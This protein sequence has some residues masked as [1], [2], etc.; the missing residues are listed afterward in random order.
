MVKHKLTVYV[1]KVIYEK[2][3]YNKDSE[4]MLLKTV[5]LNT[6]RSTN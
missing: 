2:K 5:I 4:M 3:E 6:Q 1:Y